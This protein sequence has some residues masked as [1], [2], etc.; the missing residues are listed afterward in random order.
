MRHGVGATLAPQDEWQLYD[1]TLLEALLSSPVG[2]DALRE[3]TECRQVLWTEVAAI[4]ARTRTTTDLA[5]LEAAV[6]DG[7][8]FE[9]A[10]LVAARNRF[11]RAALAAF[12]RGLRAAASRPLA[13]DGSRLEPI[14]EAVRNRDADAARVAMRARLVRRRAGK[15]TG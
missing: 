13:S 9:S 8:A 2:R 11:L 4:A 12:E 15:S 5:R 14:L 7:E 10:L 1:P 3:L 6:D